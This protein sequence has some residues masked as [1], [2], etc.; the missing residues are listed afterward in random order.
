MPVQNAEIAAMFDQ[1]AELLEIAGESQFRVRAYR[2]AARVIEGQR[3]SVR[4]LLT[5][6]RDL[7]ELPGIGKDLAGKIGDIVA[8]G[9]FELLDTLK[10]ELPG[11]LGGMAALPGLG[12]KR[13]KLLYDKLNVRSLDDL[14]RV[15]Q[16]GRLAELKGFGPVSAKK[17]AAAL[18]KPREEK[19]FRLAVAEAEAEALT[20]WLGGSRH[21]RGRI[22]VAGSLRRRRETVGDLDMLVTAKDGAAVGGRLAAYDSVVEVL[23]HGPT[24]TTV[25]LRS[26]MQVDVRAVPEESYGAALLYFTGSKAHNIALRGLAIARGWKLNEYGLFSGRRRIAG[27]TEE[28]VYRKLGLAF[29]PPEMREDRGEVALAQ[30]GALPRLV[31]VDDMRGDLHVHSDWTDGSAP[32]EAMAEAARAAGYAYMALTDHSRRVAM[33]HGLDPARVS[34]QIREIDRLNERI[35]SIT[36]LKGIEV[37]ILKDGDLDLPDATLAKLDVV[38]ASVHSFFDL[39]RDAQT[40][41]VISAMQNRHVSIIGHPSGRLIGS[42]PAYEIDMER[43]IAAARALG[44]CLEINAQPDRLDLN[45]IHAHAAKESGVRLAIST[46]SHS[47]DGF[48]NMRFGVDQA[49]RAWLTADDVINTRPLGELRKLL[50]R[51]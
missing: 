37:D 31:T 42:R 21:G 35:S 50:R 3:Q 34:R 36:I 25:V 29:I 48:R 39:P 20:A 12:P 4:S 49:R 40:E 11:D 14:R 15:L 26:G 46:D 24:R 10:K 27:A 43:V 23:A 8:T 28:D 9:H 7:S 13:V 41:R 45:D 51:A 18:E 44:C 47:V 1:A 38:V 5:S 22:A 19:R 17:L 33:A 6:G 2:R 16:N 32:I 30:A